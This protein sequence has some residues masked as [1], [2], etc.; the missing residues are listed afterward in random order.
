MTR[1]WPL[2]LSSLL[3][4]CGDSETPTGDGGFTPDAASPAALV[5]AAVQAG[6]DP[7]SLS[8]VVS[9]G[10]SPATVRQ[11]IAALDRGTKLAKWT[12]G[13]SYEH[14]LKVKLKVSALQQYSFDYTLYIPAGYQADP[15]Q[16]MAL[17]VDPAHPKT[18]L[19]E[20]Y[21]LKYMSQ[22]SGGKFLFVGVNFINKLYSTM[23]PK[24]Y[25]ALSKEGM[26]FYQDYHAA[27]DA[28]IARVKRD[29]YVDAA[30]VFISGV[31]AKG[32]SS[33]YHGIFSADQ[34]A[35][36]HPV[37]IIPSD[38][39]QDLYLNLLN[40]GIYVW[41]GTADTITPQAK[42][43]PMIDK[44]K[45]YGLKLF[46][47]EEPGGEHGGAKYWARMSSIMPI[48]LK[49][50]TRS[51]TPARV[52]KG[53]K[54]ARAAQAYWL[55]ATRFSATL[56]PAARPWPAAPPA[57]LDAT[58][59]GSTVK[60]QT[61]TGVS[62]LQLR[63]LRDAAGGPGRGQAGDTLSVQLGAG[64]AVK[65]TLKE[66]PTVALEDYCRYGDVTRLWAG[67]VTVKVN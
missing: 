64:P 62:E 55:A 60:V 66:D 21:W 4:A 41:Q 47:Y 58:W 32:A 20:T 40:V 59:S 7:A 57:V 24:A 2:L 65:H 48:L 3:L 49:T 17:W 12:T 61:H 6:C 30:K 25:D 19:K 31:S 67:R 26:A 37:S 35:A 50:Y 54:T 8:A 28:A 22:K 46:Y 51:V 53:I 38:F 23:D 52:H 36:I 29:F 34:Y 16:P 33:W 14:P 9:A 63:W 15:A 44:I 43:K 56:D 13:Y 10:H 5:Q 27:L 11:A 39:D 45:G 42:V 18:A 1:A